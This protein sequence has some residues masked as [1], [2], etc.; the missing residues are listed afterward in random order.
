MQLQWLF[1]FVFEISTWLTLLIYIIVLSIIWN[2][3]LYLW[4][5]FSSLVIFDKNGSPQSVYSGN[6][7][8][9]SLNN[10]LEELLGA[11]MEDLKEVQLYV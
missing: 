1:G 8:Y 10:F 6:Q 7:D 4:F 2:R 11:Y 5:I 9:E 3:V